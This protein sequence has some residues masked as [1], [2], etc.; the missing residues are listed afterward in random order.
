MATQLL[1]AQTSDPDQF[2]DR[3]NSPY[4][5]YGLGDLFDQGF[6]HSRGSAN[7]TSAFKSPFNVNPQNP[8]SY[9]DFIITNLE[10]GFHFNGFELSTTSETLSASDANISYLAM[11]FPI[12]KNLGFA[13]G[14]LPI[15]R[16]SYSI[17][18]D[19]ETPLGLNRT[20]FSGDGD[21]YR[22]FYGLGYS[23][24][25]RRYSVS[26]G[27]NYNFIFGNV[28]RTIDSFL[29]EETNFLRTRNRDERSYRGGHFQ[30]GFQFLVRP[31]ADANTIIVGGVS[32]DIAPS[33]DV[34]LTD[35]WERTAGGGL[36]IETQQTSS[37][38]EIDLPGRITFG[39]AI[40]N[41]NIWALGVE[42]ERSTWTNFTGFRLEN[43]FRDL[44]RYSMGFMITPDVKAFN[45][46]LKTIQYRAGVYYNTG[47]L[48][49]SDTE[50]TELGFTFGFG[51]PVRRSNAR[52][53]NYSRLNLSFDIGQRGTTDNGLIQENFIK[54]TFGITLNDRW[55]VQKKY[56]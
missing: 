39:L 52:L 55:F 44:T 15:S 21:V 34:E 25:N 35:F 48:T 20:L 4:S 18:E 43:D 17:F 33:L 28:D 32:G 46:Y 54:A 22:T 40:Q 37:E 13:I 2:I 31:K 16:V 56:D 41:S 38:N 30:Y 12:A 7:I 50:I 51:L 5:V 45:N 3:R 47:F 23:Y 8:A 24:G 11:G 26:A 6:A 1:S 27:F 42:I 29:P 53:P 14:V 49:V 10:L 9:G 36:V 19:S